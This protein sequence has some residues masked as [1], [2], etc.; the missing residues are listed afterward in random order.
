MIVIKDN[1]SIVFFFVSTII[2]IDISQKSFD[3]DDDDDGKR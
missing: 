1:I 3:D 2:N